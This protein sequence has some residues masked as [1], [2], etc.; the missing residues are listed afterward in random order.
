MIRHDL[1]LSLACDWLFTKRAGTS[2]SCS[3]LLFG[4][5]TNTNGKLAKGRYTGK[6]IPDGSVEG[7]GFL[8]V[9]SVVCTDR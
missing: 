5:N 4:A 2:E 6:F 7:E 1:K 3:L 9:S 8:S